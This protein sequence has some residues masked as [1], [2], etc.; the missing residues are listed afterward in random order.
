M[1]ARARDQI[2]LEPDVVEDPVGG[3]RRGDVGIVGA[4]G[5]IRTRRSPTARATSGSARPSRRSAFHSRWSRDRD[6]PSPGRRPYRPVRA[7]AALL[8]ARLP[9][10][11][12]P[13]RLVGV[14]L[15]RSEPVLLHPELGQGPLDAH[16]P[17]AQMDSPDV[18]RHAAGKTRK[19]RRFVAAQQTEAHERARY[20]SLAAASPAVLVPAIAVQDAPRTPMRQA[21]RARRHA[22]P[23]MRFRRAHIRATNQQGDVAELV[24]ASDL[25]SDGFGR[26][27]SSPAVPTS[28]FDMRRH[29]RQAAAFVAATR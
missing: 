10:Q 8:R 26:A 13:G 2:R 16:R 9:P 22:R 23:P 12:H 11:A 20:R 18:R 15:D 29:K 17:A 21:A 24:D 5:M 6:T 28:L 1:R 14:A 7:A 27:G 25:K 3:E 19:A 4:R